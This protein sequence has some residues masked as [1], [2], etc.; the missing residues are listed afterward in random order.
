MAREQLTS[1]RGLLT[2]D[3]GLM[4]SDE[5]L[6]IARNLVSGRSPTH[7]VGRDG[8]GLYYFSNFP[9]LYLSLCTTLPSSSRIQES[10]LR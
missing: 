10:K 5:G 2:S 6:M 3:E 4:T 1:D 7:I 9:F 8:V